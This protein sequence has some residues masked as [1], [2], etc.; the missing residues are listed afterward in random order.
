M[1]K[2]FL[3]I[4][5]FLTAFT[6]VGCGCEKKETKKEEEKKEEEKLDDDTVILE[7]IKYKLDQDD[8]EYGITYKIASNFR[9]STMI[10]AVNYFSEN[11]GESPYFV[12]RIYQYPGKDIEYAIKDSVETVEQRETVTVGDKEYTKVYFT[13][14]NGAKTHLYYYTH[15][16]TT[17]TFVFTAGIDLS[18]LEDIFLKSIIYN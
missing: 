10:N 6:L 7:N 17:Y 1:K 8:T 14:Y 4:F 18:R 2:V 13:N 11:I 3:S 15:N 12:I 16:Q 9:K 5:I